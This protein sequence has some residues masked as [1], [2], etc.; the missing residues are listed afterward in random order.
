MRV[1]FTEGEPR[2]TPLTK[3]KEY[4]VITSVYRD[5]KIIGAEIF[6]DEGN[7]INIYIP[8]CAF[9]SDKPWEVIDE[10]ESL[11]MKV[12]SDITTQIVIEKFGEGTIVEVD[13]ETRFAEEPQDFFNEMYDWVETLIN[14]LQ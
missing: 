2:T 1:K 13:G 9:L 8:M 12:I 14:K 4:E 3:G 7:L 11:K 6:N 10:D 5:G